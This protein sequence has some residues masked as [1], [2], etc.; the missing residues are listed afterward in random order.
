M[1]GYE[2]HRGLFAERTAAIFGWT[3]LRV[4]RHKRRQRLCGETSSPTL[5]FASA[6][7]LLKRNGGS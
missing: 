6:A 3:C 5:I 1:R 7:L 4:K 2:Q